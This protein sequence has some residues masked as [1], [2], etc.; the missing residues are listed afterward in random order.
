M[1]D[2]L[3]IQLSSK[4][5]RA[6]AAVE[7]C[8]GHL[9]SHMQS[10]MIAL[11]QMSWAEIQIVTPHLPL[12][13]E[14]AV[15]ALCSLL[16]SQRKQ[17]AE[18]VTTALA[19][20]G[21]PRASVPLVQMMERQAGQANALRAR[22][23][24][25]ALG[26]GA[27]P[28]LVQAVRSVNWEVRYHA[29]QALAVIGDP[30]SIEEL[31][32]LATDDRSTKVR[33]AAEEAMM[34]IPSVG[35]DQMYRI[36]QGFFNPG[37]TSEVIFPEWRVDVINANKSVALWRFDL[38]DL[39]SSGMVSWDDACISGVLR[40]YEDLGQQ[41]NQIDA[42]LLLGD[43]LNEASMATHFAI[44]LGAMDLRTSPPDLI[45]NFISA[46]HD[47]LSTLPGADIPRSTWLGNLDLFPKCHLSKGNVIM[48]DNDDS[49]T[50][51]SSLQDSNDNFGTGYKFTFAKAVLDDPWV[52]RE[53]LKE[54]KGKGKFEHI[55]L[56]SNEVAELPSLPDDK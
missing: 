14:E 42:I 37:V 3:G 50:P 2:D 16:T 5:T 7:V 46:V 4:Q 11:D 6:A 39:Q 17:T 27:V 20:I 30:S 33:E 8:Q 47:R 34:L 35:R 41:A 52:Y 38:N 49:Y 24:L 48:Y 53:R 9:V 54:L 44:A 22:D 21:D 1:S 56:P 23:A 13:G 26:S 19:E 15:P 18:A 55:P 45:E 40:A 25:I 32:D 10:L 31:V 28:A 51:D 29:V 43:I 12:L 36:Q